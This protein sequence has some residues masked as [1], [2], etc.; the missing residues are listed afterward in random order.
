MSVFGNLRQSGQEEL[1]NV[2]KK[3]Y[4]KLKL[5]QTEVSALNPFHVRL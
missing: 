4:L 1:G 5:A 2:K 3:T